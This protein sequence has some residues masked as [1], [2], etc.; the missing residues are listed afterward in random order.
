MRDEEI[1][2]KV[3]EE[4]SLLERWKAPTTVKVK[5]VKAIHCFNTCK[6]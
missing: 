4:G 2:E 1:C 5:S 6:T 3:Q